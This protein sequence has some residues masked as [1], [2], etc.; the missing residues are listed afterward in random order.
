LA[1]STL[2]ANRGYL[3]NTTF[4][5]V[6]KWVRHAEAVSPNTKETL[7]AKIRFLMFQKKLDEALARVDQLLKLDSESVRTQLV[8]AEYYMQA[9]NYEEAKKYLDLVLAQNP[10]HIRAHYV[11]AKLELAQG[12]SEQGEEKLH[13]LMNNNAHL[14]SAVEY[15]ANRYEK[16]DPSVFE[17]LQKLMNESGNQMSPL[18]YSLGYKILSE[19]FDKEGKSEESTLALEKAVQ[20]MTLND[21]YAFELGEKYEKQKNY[22]KSV[23]YLNQA[24]QLDKSNN[25]YAIAYGRNLRWVGK[26]K[27]AEEILKPVI[28]NAPQLEDGI[29]QYAESRADQ[30]LYEDVISFLLSSLEK[31]PKMA[32]VKNL[33]GELYVEQNKFDQASV[34]F[35]QALKVAKTDYDRSIVNRSLGT[36][37]LKQEKWDSALGYLKKSNQEDPGNTYTL[38]ALGKAYYYKSQYKEAE[39]AIIDALN[40]DSTNSEARGVLAQIYFD[41]GKVEEAKKVINEVLEDDPKNVPLRV[42]LGKML[43]EENQFAEAID[44]LDEAYLYDSENY[45]TYYYLGIAERELG[46]VDYALRSFSRAI[47]IWGDSHNAY[48]QRGLTFIRKND[49][50]NANLDMKKA[51]EL[52]PDWPLPIKAI[53]KYYFEVSLYDQSTEYY[54]KIVK[55]DPKDEEALFYLGKSYFFQEKPEK[56]LEQFSKLIRLNPRHA[57]GYYEIGVIFEDAG[58]FPQAVT[59]LQKS[60]S[61]DPSNPDVYYHLGFVM[62]NL[63]KRK[64]AAGYFQ[65]HLELNPKSI[66][67]EALED[68]IFRLNTYK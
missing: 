33:L 14:A 20:K 10:D 2:L 54:Q 55:V 9:Q 29:V 5:D 53:A 23:Q 8:A 52:K 58:D 62:K 48:Y 65:K 28:V 36:L 66:E 63:N 45:E 26:S 30:G 60:Q 59:Y 16:K 22:A 19:I 41:K 3:D 15:Y 35:L 50:S 57:K 44:H 4:N 67:K 51:I 40:I 25:Q 68:E 38:F 56:A 12:N 42:T 61:L 47:E 32:R 39:S 21:Q 6:Q 49:I 17:N 27:E 7:R 46:K 37:A 43:I 24:Y 34:V 13:A 18:H 31:D 64:Q 11:L 1:S